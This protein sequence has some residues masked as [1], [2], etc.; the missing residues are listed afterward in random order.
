MDG[1][2]SII[3]L[4]KVMDI[5]DKENDEDDYEFLLFP[6]FPSIEKTPRGKDEDL[7]PIVE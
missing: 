3:D 1:D 4:Q 2:P 6:V 7:T 5:N